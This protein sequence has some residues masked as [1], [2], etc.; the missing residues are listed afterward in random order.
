MTTDWGIYEEILS[1]IISNAIKFNEKNE[2]IN[3]D[4]FYHELDDQLLD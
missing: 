2:C 1:L 3:F 4:L